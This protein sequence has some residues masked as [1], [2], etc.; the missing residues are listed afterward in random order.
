MNGKRRHDIR[1]GPRG[2]STQVPDQ[3]RG[4]ITGGIVKDVLTTSADHPHGIKARLGTAEVG[5]VQEMVET[6]REVAA[7]DRDQSVR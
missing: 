2:D 4:R 5:R 1:P 7:T 3:R 6:S